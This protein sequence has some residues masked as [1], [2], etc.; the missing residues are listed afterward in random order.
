[1]LTQQDLE[2]HLRREREERARADTAADPSARRS[3]LELAETHAR[4]A[5][6]AKIR[7]S[8]VDKAHSI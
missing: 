5:A 1:M 8:I 7:L 6:Q 3:H 2:H 4:R